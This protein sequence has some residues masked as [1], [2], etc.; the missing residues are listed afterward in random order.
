MTRA[1]R[2][3]TFVLRISTG[4]LPQIIELAERLTK[5]AKRCSCERGETFGG[6]MQGNSLPQG[7]EITEARNRKNIHGSLGVGYL[8]TLDACVP[9]PV[10]AYRDLAALEIQF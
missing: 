9:C 1:G 6:Q 7:S 10:V 5:P 3:L 8:S 2:S 4:T